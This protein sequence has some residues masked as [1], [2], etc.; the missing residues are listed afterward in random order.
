MLKRGTN[1]NHLEQARTTWNELELPGNTCNEMDSATDWHGK[2]RNS[3]QET[4]R[5]MP[6]ANRIQH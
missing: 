3:S 4:V 2:T 1:C 5:S 6:L